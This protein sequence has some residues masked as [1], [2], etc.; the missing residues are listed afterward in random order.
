MRVPSPADDRSPAAPVPNANLKKMSRRGE[1][2]V[3]GAG[4]VADGINAVL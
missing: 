1:V 3:V 4:I 2:N